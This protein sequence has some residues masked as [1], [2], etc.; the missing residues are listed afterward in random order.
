MIQVSPNT[1][2]K[3]NGFVLL[4]PGIIAIDASIWIK[5]L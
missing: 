2:I 5:L 1:T 3:S 4:T